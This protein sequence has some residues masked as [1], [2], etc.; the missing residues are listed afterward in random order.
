MTFTYSEQTSSFLHARIYL[1]E[2]RKLKT[3]LCQTR[4]DCNEPR[5][6]NHLVRKQTKFFPTTHIVAEKVLFIHKHSNDHILQEELSKLIRILLARAYQLH[7]IIKLIKKPLTKIHNHLLSQQT[8]HRETNILAIVT[9]FSSIGK[10]FEAAIHKHWHTIPD[11]ATPL[12]S[13]HPNLYLLIQNP[14]AFTTT[15]STLHK[16]IAYLSKILTPQ[17]TYTVVQSDRPTLTLIRLLSSFLPNGSIY[18]I[19]VM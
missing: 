4:C 9:P 14:T 16:Q 7:L 17:F 11:D 19:L 6:H 3:K 13:G 8:T 18:W 10:S 5:T 1:S 12:T 15:L 2:S